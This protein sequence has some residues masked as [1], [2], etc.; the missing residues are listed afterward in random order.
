MSFLT[1][2]KDLASLEIAHF[3]SVIKENTPVMKNLSSTSCDLSHPVDRRPARYNPA[4]P[5]TSSSRL[6]FTF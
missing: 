5:L 1:P 6:A 2:L 3:E 4:T